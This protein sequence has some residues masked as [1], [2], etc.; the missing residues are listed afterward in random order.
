[1]LFIYYSQYTEGFV[2]INEISSYFKDIIF[3][4]IVVL[5]KML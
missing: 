1:M 2:S 5:W 3:G 4:D